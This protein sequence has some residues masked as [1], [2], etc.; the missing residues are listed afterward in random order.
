MAKIS[1]ANLNTVL[2]LI[3]TNLSELRFNSSRVNIN[4][5]LQIRNA[6]IGLKECDWSSFDNLQPVILLDIE[7]LVGLSQV[8]EKNLKSIIETLTPMVSLPNYP[9]RKLQ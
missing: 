6:G 9:L 2:A 3:E 8:T 4:L 1:L 5:Q 7:E